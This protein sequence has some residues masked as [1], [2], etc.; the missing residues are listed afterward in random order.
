LTW[1]VRDG[2]LNHSKSYVDI[3]GDGWTEVGTTEGQ[4]VKIADIVAYVNHDVNDAIRAGVINENEIPSRVSERLGCRSS[5]RINTLVLDII[6][7]TFEAMER[8]SD[9][10]CITMSPELLEIANQLREFLFDKVY[11]SALAIKDKDKAKEVV[12]VLFSYLSKHPEKLPEEYN[13]RNDTIERKVT[14]YIA[15]MTDQYAVLKASK[16]SHKKFVFT[17]L[18]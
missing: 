14:D 13:F 1:E 7:H 8:A 16:I 10:V 9:T 2:I 18:L 12:A 5:E 15:G 6:H 4:V 3:F 11:N 17:K